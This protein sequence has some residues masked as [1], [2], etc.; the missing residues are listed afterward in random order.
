MWDMAL[1]TLELTCF[2]SPNKASQRTDIKGPRSHARGLS[3]TVI[4]CPNIVVLV[5]SATV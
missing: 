2:I 5:L 1:V 4:Y 3:L